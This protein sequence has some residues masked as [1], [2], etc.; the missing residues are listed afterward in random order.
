MSRDLKGYQHDIPA[1]K[2]PGGA[3]IFA[4]EAADG[5]SRPKRIEFRGERVVA[6]F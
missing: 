5:G 3:R 1:V 6:N 2:W 4:M